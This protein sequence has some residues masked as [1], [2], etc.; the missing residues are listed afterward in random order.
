MSTP[1]TARQAP[2]IGRYAIDAAASKVTFVTRHIFGLAQVRGTF[3]VTRGTLTVADPAADS[4][5]EAEL[6]SASFSTR[7][8][9]RDPQIRSR[10]FLGVRRHRAITF[11]TTG[12]RPSGGA[13]AVT[14][15]LTVKGRPA[16]IELTLSDVRAEGA[17][18]VFRASGTVDRYAHGVTSMRGMAAR[19]L[20]V[21]ITAHA[22]PA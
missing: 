22:T 9:M 20:S 19:R 15:V 1:M 11:R 2:P 6:A 18:F 10:L 21:E 17:S 14:G 4:S 5:A 12:V 13:W 16:P 8:F 3:A 7:N